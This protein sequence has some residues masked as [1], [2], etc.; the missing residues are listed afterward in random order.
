M[1][2]DNLW[3]AE[4]YSRWT[5]QKLIGDRIRTIRKAAGVSQE[6]LGRRINYSDSAISAFEN[7]DRAPSLLAAFSLA[8]NLNCSVEDF[9]PDPE[10]C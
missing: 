5:A 1:G 7:G 10:P 8:D 3:V 2:D 4:E 9:R 6:Q